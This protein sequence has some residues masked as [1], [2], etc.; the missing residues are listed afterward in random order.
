MKLLTANRLADGTVVWLTAEGAWSE[1]S[2][3][4]ARL[5]TEAAAAALVEA[6]RQF[7]TVVGAYLID[8]D[9]AGTIVA[10]E[11]LRETIRAKGPTAGHSLKAA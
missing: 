2:D 8:A 9:E 11:R 4:A 10:R 6:E 7:R 1:Q 5:D 3:A